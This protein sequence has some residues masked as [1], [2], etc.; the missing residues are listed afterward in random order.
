MRCI[1]TMILMLVAGTAGAQPVSYQLVGDVALGQKPALRVS[2]ARSVTG[3]QIELDRDDGKHFT[4]RHAALSK[5]QTVTLPIGDGS[6]GKASYKGKLSVQITGEGKWSDELAFETLV[7]APFKL[8]YDADHLDLDKRVLQFKPSRAA[9]SAELVVIGE[10]GKQ[11]GTGSATYKHEPADS[12]LSITWT[13][14]AGTRVMIM[15]LRVVAADGLAT[16]LE[17]IPWSVTIDHEDVKFS[18][19]S[20]VIDAREEVK[21]GASLSRITEVVKRGERFMKMTL[22]VAGHTD[23]V[24]T[25]ENNRKL[26]QARA[27]AIAKYFRRKG[28]RIPIAIAGFGEDVLKVKTP[29]GTDEPANRRADYVIGPTGATPPFKGPYL[30]V[31]ARWQQLR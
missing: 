3:L 11:L 21:L 10:D 2:A 28:L 27:G 29:D 15:K 13:Q 31:R 26:S 23:T 17:L 20:A 8:S 5:G 25:N 18:V 14:P 19:D 12:W 16:N 6:A 22:Y 1:C 24:G 9:A 30:K 7:R 4:M